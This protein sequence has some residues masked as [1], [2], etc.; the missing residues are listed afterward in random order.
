MFD[1]WINRASAFIEDDGLIR[2]GSGEKED[3]FTAPSGEH[4]AD[5]AP[6]Y[7]REVFGDFTLTCRVKPDFCSFY[8]AGAIL[9]YVGPD[10]WVKLAF[11]STDL[12]HTS[13]V[14]VVTRE[15]SD[16]ANGERCDDESVL[17]RLTRKGQVMGLYHSLDGETWKMVRTYR[18]LVEQGKGALVGLVSQ[19]PAGKGCVAEFTEISFTEE[20]IKD[21]RKGI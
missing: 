21:M 6:A 19:S 18:H 12:N 11:E 17:L 8:D 15:F 10:D 5:N 13:L 2:I 14:S 9:F 4:R 16:D 1:K 7:V 20:S 3:F